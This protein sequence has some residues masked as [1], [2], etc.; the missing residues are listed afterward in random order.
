MDVLAS[1]LEAVHLSGAVLFRV[2]FGDP[3]AYSAP[4]SEQYA[5]MLVRHARRLMIFHLVLEGGCLAQVGNGPPIRVEGGDVIMLPRGDALLLADPSFPAAESIFGCLPPFPWLEAPHLRLGGDG[6]KTQIICGFLHTDEAILAPLVT[7]LPS[8]V[9]VKTA[10]A[11]PRLK[12]M[13]DYTADEM[14]EGRPGSQS[15]VNRLAEIL[16]IEVLRHTLT[17]SAHTTL[18]A[19]LRDPIVGRTLE[20]LHREPERGWTIAAMAQAAASS[21]TLVAERF[22]ALVGCPP[23]EYLTRWRMQLAARRLAEGRE[24]IAAVAEAVGYQSEAA[25]N[26]A[27]RRYL[28]ATPA[29]FRRQRQG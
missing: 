21:R 1:V 4:P 12:A 14:R 10:A 22:H 28:G 26:R 18:L 9:V 17:D 11:L 8:L 29:A 6:P 20:A 3:F 16:F 13:F 15:V 2:A 5:P 24:S 27:F 23:I 25:F 7:D 19:A